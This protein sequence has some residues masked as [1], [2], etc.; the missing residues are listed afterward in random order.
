M[1]KVKKI[2]SFMLCMAM[3][4]AL[5]ISAFADGLAPTSAQSSGEYP[6]GLYDGKEVTLVNHTD[7]V[8]RKTAG[9]EKW[10]SNNTLYVGYSLTVNSA[11][12]NYV[13]GLWWSKITPHNYSNPTYVNAG[14]SASYLLN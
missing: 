2:V 11:N 13:N 4:L 12:C 9:G 6:Y 3:I 5:S 10:S 7:I 14:Y 8:V 1:N